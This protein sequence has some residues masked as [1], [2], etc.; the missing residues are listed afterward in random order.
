M[1]RETKLLGGAAMGATLFGLATLGA[2]GG[3]SGSTECRYQPWQG[4]CTLHSVQTIQ[5]IERFPKSFVVVEAIYQAQSSD[6]RLAPQFRQEFT[7]PAV[8]EQQL[9]DH[10]RNNG[11]N[12]PCEGKEAMGACGQPGPAQARVPQFAPSAD[13]TLAVQG[14]TGCAKLDDLRVKTEAAATGSGGSAN[15]AAAQITNIPPF[16]F[17]ENSDATTAEHASLAQ[18]AAQ[19]LRAHPEI[20]CIAIVGQIARGE[21]IPLAE[22]R[23]RAIKQLITGHGV[24]ATRIVTHGATV[25]MSGGQAQQVGAAVDPKLRSVRLSVLL[26]TSPAPPPQ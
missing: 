2:C 22:N 9:H 20:E 7:A 18:R 1:G 5:I 14:P 3:P 12:I 15:P 23:A 11:R 17:A 24:A 6:G 8:N 10:L 13:P 19:A 25:P 21:P 26:V 4:T 16:T